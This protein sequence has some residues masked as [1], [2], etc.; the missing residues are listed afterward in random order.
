MKSTLVLVCLLLAGCTATPVDIGEHLAPGPPGV[1]AAILA[2]LDHGS[3][4]A[5]EIHFASADGSKGTAVLVTRQDAAAVA[6]YIGGGD[7][8]PARDVAPVARDFEHMGLDAL[9][10]EYPLA[11][12]DGAARLDAARMS[13]LGAYDYLDLRSRFSR[14]PIIVH[15]FDTGSFVASYIARQRAVAGLVLED[16]PT[17]LRDWAYADRPW[18]GGIPK[19][20]KGVRDENN[21][22]AVNSYAGPLLLLAG[23]ED[24]ATPPIFAKALYRYALT[25]RADKHLIMVADASHGQTLRSMQAQAAYRAFARRIADTEKLDDGG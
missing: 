17:S 16:A 1:P 4:T 15:G 20:K 3:Y 22:I 24:K 19:A 9:I 2:K 23:G 18:Y 25:P 8:L 21:L 7:F 6:L 14:L 12:G 13:A 11:A 10:V 5:R